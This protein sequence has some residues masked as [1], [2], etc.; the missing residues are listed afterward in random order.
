MAIT[1]PTYVKNLGKSLGYIGSDVFSSYAPTMASLAKTTKEA[2][3]S[4]YQA[5]KDFTSSS[6]SS[7]FSF[8][9]I[10]SKGGELASNIWKNTIDDIK[11]GKLYN[12]ER[13]DALD[14]EMMKGMGFDFD[15]DFDLDDWGDE[16]ITDSDDEAKAQVAASVEGSKAI[17]NAV[18]AMGRG[19]TASINNATV[20]SAS[21]IAASAKED[22]L[23]L[24][25]LN[26][27]GYASI[28]KALMSVNDSINNFSKIGE[29]LT[30]H[31]QNS[32]AFFSKA[33]TSLHNIEQ[34]LKQIEKNT[35]P[36]SALNSRSAKK[37][38]SLS[39]VFTDDGGIDFGELKDSIKESVE[40]WKELASMFGGA[41]KGTLANGGKNISLAGMISKGI[42]ESI[43]PDDFKKS[44]K[45]LDKSIKYGLQAGLAKMGGGNSGNFLID[46]LAGFIMPE[47]GRDKRSVGTK[48]EKGPVAWD[49]IA[50]KALVDVIPTTLLEIYSALTGA[51]SQ[52]YDYNN[53]KFIKTS[54]IQGLFQ[55]DKEK[56]VKDSAEDF[57]DEIE[58]KLASRKGMSQEKKDKMM[59]E[60]YKYFEKAFDTGDY[61]IFK[62][63]HGIDP[64]A[65]KIIRNIAIKSL[66]SNDREKRTLLNKTVAKSL[67]ANAEYA[68]FLRSEEA[69]G[70]S[71]YT[72]LNSG[73]NAKK[74]TA[75]IGGMIGLDKFGHDYYFY[76]QGIWQ[77][78]NFIANN[79]GIIGGGGGSKKQRLKA[80]ADLKSQSMPVIPVDT[81]T[82]G[83]RTTEESNTH[84]GG[85]Y[86]DE[87]IE[88][89][90]EDKKDRLKKLIGGFSDKTKEFINSVFGTH[91]TPGQY[92]SVQIMDSISNSINRL[93]F[94]TRD[95]ASDGLMGYMFKKTEELF[96][97]AKKWF[98]E[99]V[100]D[101]FKNWFM[102]KI[103]NK[104]KD[105]WNESQWVQGTKDRLKEIKDSALGS[106]KK[107]FIGN[108]GSDNGT[109]AYGRK[110]TKTG[111]V[112]V[113]EGEL[114]I[115]SE[116]NPFYHGTT[117]KA[118]QIANEMR[119]SGG[120]YPMYALGDIPG[121]G[122]GSLPSG[123]LGTLSNDGGLN[124]KT[125]SIKN[126]LHIYKKKKQIEDNSI[127]GIL[128]H[129]ADGVFDK[130]KEVTDEI[131]D[132]KKMEKD[133]KKF[134]DKITDII[135]D[136]GGAK[137]D[138]GAG[139]VI[140]GLGTTLVGIN[141][142]FGAFMGAG[143]GFMYK[144]K[145]F[146]D[147]LFGKEDENG[148]RKHQKA[149]DFMMREVPAIGKG[150]GFGMAAGVFMGSP[151]L[152]AFL[153]GATGF[154]L[155]NEKFQDFLFGEKDE[156]GN[157]KGGVLA[158]K[159]FENVDNTFHNIG[160]K[161]SR[162]LKDLGKGIKDK[163]TGLIDNLKEKS[164]DPNSG[165]FTKLIG[166]ALNLGGKALRLPFNIASGITGAIDTKIAK[167]NLK[168]GYS[169]YNKA[170]NRNM[171]AEERIKTRS[172][173]KI[174]ANDFDNFDKFLASLKNYKELENYKELINTIKVEPDGSEEQQAAINLLVNDPKYKE[175]VGDTS[176]K[177]LAKF[178][179]KNAGK[180]SDLM[181]DESK[182]KGM[183]KADLEEAREEK[184]LTILDR[185]RILV[186]SLVTHKNPEDIAKE[187]DKGNQKKGYHLKANQ[188][189]GYHLKGKSSDNDTNETDKEK[190]S[191][192]DINEEV[193][194]ETETS[195]F[196]KALN[197]I[198]TMSNKRFSENGQET[199]EAPDTDTGKVIKWIKNSNGKWNLQKMDKDTYE[200][201][202]K[203]SKFMETISN[204]PGAIRGLGS[205]IKEALF[206]NG[207]D[208]EGLFGKAKK[209]LSKIANKIIKPLIGV[210]AAVFAVYAIFKGL[211]GGQN[212]FINKFVNKIGGVLGFGKASDNPF[213]NGGTKT[214]FQDAEG[215]ILSAQT[216]ENGI[217][218][219][220]NENGEMVDP[221]NVQRVRAGTDTLITRFRKTSLRQLVTGKPIIAAKA[222]KLGV[223]KAPI[224]GK[225]LVAGGE[226]IASKV[227]TLNS[228]LGK[229]W[230]QYTDDAAKTLAK[231]AD[232]IVTNK[233]IY[234]LAG[235]NFGKDLTEIMESSNGPIMVKV[236]EFLESAAKHVDDLPIPAGVKKVLPS[237]YDDLA[238]NIGKNAGK[239]MS[240][241]GPAAKNISDAIPVI[242]V[243]MMV[244]DFVTGYEDARTT[245]GITAEPSIPQ[246]IISGLIRFLKNLIPVVGPFIPDDLIVNVACKWIAPVFG[247][248]DSE[249][250][251][252]R[253][254]A[255]AEVAA[256]NAEHGTNYSVAEYNK[257]VLNDY[258]F[259][260]RIGN[261][262]KTAKQQLS[263]KKS[264]IAQAY[265]SHG[266]GLKGVGYAF[267]EISGFSKMMN[268]YNEAGGGLKGI[269]EANMAFFSNI[270]GNEIG[271]K[272]MQ[273]AKY[274]FTGDKAFWD[275]NNSTL[276]AFKDSSAE[277][278]VKSSIFSKY[279]G[280]LPFQ[281]MKFTLTPIAAITTAGRSLFEKIAEGFKPVKE[282][283]NNFKSYLSIMLKGDQ[284]GEVATGEQAQYK[285][286]SALAPVFNFGAKIIKIASVLKN[287]VNKV[288]GY[289]SA[290]T[291]G[292][293]GGDE[294]VIAKLSK[295][296]ISGAVS[297]ITTNIATKTT[298]G[299]MIT[300]GVN[301]V[302]GAW[303]WLTGKSSTSSEASSGAGSG[304][305]VNN[306]K[307]TCT[308]CN[309]AFQSQL[310]PRYK[311]ISFGGSTVGEAGCG[312][313]V[314][315]MASAS[316]GGNLDMTTAI[317]KARSYTNNDGT[318]AKYFE[319]TLNASPLN[320]TST[321]KSALES[322]RPV[323]LLGKDPSNKSKENSPFGPNN[324]YVLATG[325][326]NGKV[327]V[328]DPE[329]NGPKVYDQSIL[330]KSNYN[331]T[332]GGSSRRRGRGGFDSSSADA[333][334]IW[335]YLTTKQ[336]YTPQGAAG[337]MG[338]WAEESSLNPNTIEG[339]YLPG[340][341]GDEAVRTTSG[342]NDFTTNVLFPAYSSSGLNIDKSAYKG[343]DGNYYPGFGLAQWTG[344][345]GQS[346]H[347]YSNT[348][349]SDWFTLDN[350][351]SYFS[352]EMAGLYSGTDSKLKNATDVDQATKDAMNGYEGN[353]ISSF[354]EKRKPW[355]NQ[356]YNAFKDS[357]YT[358]DGSASSSS[359]SSSTSNDES[360]NTAESSSSSGGLLSQLSTIFG[361]LTNIFDISNGFSMN[362]DSSG[363]SNS[364]SGTTK[365][366]YKAR[367]NFNNGNGAQ[368]AANAAS[369]E[370]DYAESGNNITKFGAWSG[371]NGQPWC[372]AFA[373]WAIAQAFDGSKD[374][375]VEA[376]YNCSN[377][378][379]TPTLTD[380]FKANNAW[381]QEPEVGDEVMY[382]N[383]GPYHVGI[384][385][386][387][388]KDAKTFQSVEGNSSDKVQ[389]K[390]H[391]G[392]LEGDVIGF[393]RPD[394]SGATTNITLHN[395]N[396]TIAV[397]GDST[398]FKATGSGLR[399]GSSGLLRKAAP[400]RFAYGSMKGQRFRFGGASGLASANR[401]S[402][403]SNAMK[404]S[405][406]NT[407]SSIKSSL[408]KSNG[409]ISGV[410]PSLVAELLSS[411]T[412]LLN[413][414]A[415]NTAPTERIY[416]AL[417]EY[418][419]YIKGNKTSS[420]S[421]SSN[422]QVT[423]P[424]SNDEIDS[425]LAGLVSTL[426]A[427]AKG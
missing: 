127:F 293:I 275:K 380:T 19:M 385:T 8:K 6:G 208:K 144:S 152:G 333:Q 372:A 327:L 321:V 263:D 233:E 106:V 276:D 358:Y 306:S 265:K 352:S 198:N 56:K 309:S 307:S 57:L 191:D 44:L 115:P 24:F 403:N 81:V 370:I 232:E 312:P 51:P 377:V 135:G 137:G 38:R 197:S 424:R 408:T 92:A 149:Y 239:I 74:N 388:D 34:S 381:Y 326:K 291:G 176:A 243:V 45:G 109:A 98:K 422:E 52:R 346:L 203:K 274:A 296:D 250:M 86:D 420:S 188:I 95:D 391:S 157:R 29:P 244:A 88:N 418:I 277:N 23:A 13:Q 410:D 220:F 7:D 99:N 337:I 186:E 254:E 125:F 401:F 298:A 79:L 288:T 365:T 340:Y 133:E 215:N 287:L 167:G 93:L 185:I 394:Y 28:N 387:V 39:D 132:K 247:L 5:I 264:A 304:L 2:T 405:V 65:Y 164:K 267:D 332:F 182:R 138:I 343:T 311:D 324:H 62:E 190:S 59:E 82:S 200:S 376:L 400:S 90:K 314:A 129:A 131:F 128:F 156:N 292:L 363:T 58:N 231:N 236:R 140:G 382:G 350:Q 406:T 396:S 42:V 78:T 113:S 213:D 399:G 364:D 180:L 251:K 320:N 105:K 281:T 258:T 63:D 351:L 344:P 53:G 21:Y 31:M 54:S 256:Y 97:N 94:G 317:N 80:A 229:V 100:I 310:D 255:K 359:S 169:T 61:N 426:A 282:D 235:E 375:A 331:L 342:L 397:D 427:I 374:K 279:I 300:T 37:V 414:I 392:Y 360:T 285:A 193:S 142:L 192:N 147:F 194:E 165:F 71:I 187:S 253:D 266:G 237:L 354:L 110:V 48:F 413:N 9:G 161:L 111:I 338:C 371:C 32:Y 154:M 339:F 349:G 160:N 301:M 366:G 283:Y 119:I 390:D 228:S 43:I 12:K 297:D 386:S 130:A 335:A 417:T 240:K 341:P 384:V 108:D 121:G 199:M 210:A 73:F 356:I 269:W 168:G 76:L 325:M 14:S 284:E 145:S 373:A 315:A 16:D 166:G 189:K 368:A 139:A 148:E 83:E 87:N 355:A 196:D 257:S 252:Q 347:E 103:G 47:T 425:N 112:T 308:T 143:L 407:L 302:K 126:K 230:G 177:K 136:I 91:L 329:S 77:F 116:Y 328:N 319:D 353:N 1:I 404:T 15:F 25:N 146:Q 22:S 150:A 249:L 224:I 195:G 178:F 241:L 367:A 68:N 348:S 305:A 214:Q 402:S 162:W 286:T 318:S 361:S 262:F 18:D 66:R 55:K 238:E 30:A 171:T 11:T 104:V 212:S 181:N 84:V 322:G 20:E 419:D 398:D 4:T 174:K 70:S 75:G 122:L 159:I 134:S 204:I 141:P 33:E 209:F 246:R 272:T 221:S 280:S 17:I 222:L 124:A 334:Q 89:D 316:M 423:M 395:R 123:G 172:K 211:F 416:N 260:E 60:A 64:E 295:G 271:T 85:Y 273:L 207:D 412:S 158:N 40:G 118:S 67:E 183:S 155:S 242:N 378:N 35:T 313:A 303:A 170:W 245:L 415:N 117:N 3:S 393:G 107:V 289:I 46:T 72:A 411:I 216:D 153:G 294:S 27:A 184:K 49:G 10:T 270:P 409:N 218:N 102:N 163:V 268:A 330:N 202:K 50:R 357:N 223:S 26:K 225:K 369:N 151:I 299:K 383:P 69:S 226:K 259:T 36:I 205:K 389:L 120:R 421:S 96:D 323:V 345:R 219:Y 379:Y 261:T 206:G 362:S 201:T 101:K 114:I 336:G 234:K 248:K 217:T 227:G 41:G 175:F 179:K 173:F 290:L 278:G